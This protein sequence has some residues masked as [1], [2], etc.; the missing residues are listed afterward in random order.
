[1]TKRSL[2]LC[3]DDDWNRL[4]GRKMLL[5]EREYQVLVATG[6]AVAGWIFYRLIYPHL[7]RD[8]RN[9]F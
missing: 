8:G 6:G 4:E 2:I 5:E 1:M 9:R 3:V 7:K